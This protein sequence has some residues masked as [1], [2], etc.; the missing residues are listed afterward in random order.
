MFYFI[1]FVLAAAVAFYAY[2]KL[3]EELA[4]LEAEDQ[5][6]AKTVRAKVKKKSEGVETLKK[7]P[8]TGV[9]RIDDE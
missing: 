1:A 5:K 2:S 4:K 6:A 9:Y 7:D 3:R 8:K